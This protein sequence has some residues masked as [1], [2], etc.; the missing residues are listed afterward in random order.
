MHRPVQ[1]RIH[2]PPDGIPFHRQQFPGKKSISPSSVAALRLFCKR[3]DWAINHAPESESI[4]QETNPSNNRLYCPRAWLFFR[5]TRP[6]LI[7]QLNGVDQLTDATKRANW[8]MLLGEF[9]VI[10]DFTVA[11]VGSK[12]LYWLTVVNVVATEYGTDLAYLPTLQ[13]FLHYC[14]FPALATG[15]VPAPFITPFTTAGRWA[16]F[17]HRAQDR[18]QSA[19]RYARGL[20]LMLFDQINPACGRSA[21]VAALFAWPCASS[22]QRLSA[23]WVAV[24]AGG[25]NAPRSSLAGNGDLISVVV[26]SKPCS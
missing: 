25:A 10:A 13:N 2:Q 8:A 24:V 26:V 21:K 6:V 12:S 15:S 16:Q 4:A 14:F 17:I 7:T 5:C 20:T 19:D 18:Y 23:D 3:Y 22:H 11:T 1:K 9:A